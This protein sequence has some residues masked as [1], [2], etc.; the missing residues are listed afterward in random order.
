MPPELVMGTQPTP[1]M[2][3]SLSK[4][5][6]AVTLNAGE[7]RVVDLVLVRFEEQ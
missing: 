4:V 6:T 1:E 2:F 7:R 5:A 3:E